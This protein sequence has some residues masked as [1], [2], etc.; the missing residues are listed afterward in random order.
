MIEKGGPG[1]REDFVC[2]VYNELIGAGG[3]VVAFP[4]PGDSFFDMGTPDDLA[5]VR[6][7]LAALPRPRTAA[8]A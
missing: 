2:P 1:R 4:I 7:R 6:R 8:T 3:T 5:D